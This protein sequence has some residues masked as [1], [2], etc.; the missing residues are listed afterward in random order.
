M[1]DLLIV[2]CLWAVISFLMHTY[3]K[4]PK[5]YDAYTLVMPICTIVGLLTLF[6]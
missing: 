1:K 5:R 3:T 4:E 6:E 2:F